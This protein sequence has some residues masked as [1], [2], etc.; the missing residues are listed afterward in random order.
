MWYLN[1]LISAVSPFTFY[2]PHYCLNIIVNMLWFS[3]F[4][5]CWH[6]YI[7]TVLSS[8]SRILISL[9]SRILKLLLLKYSA[10]SPY[11]LKKFISAIYFKMF[12]IPICLTTMLSAQSH[13]SNYGW[14]LHNVIRTVFPSLSTSSTNVSSSRLKCFSEQYWYASLFMSST[15]KQFFPVHPLCAS[16]PWA[17]FLPIPP[18]FVKNIADIS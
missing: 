3:K 7:K 9:S 15:I 8:L 1:I 4:G 18:R 17:A 16:P 2:K 10:L 13:A 11:A 5:L 12:Y 14:Y 6:K